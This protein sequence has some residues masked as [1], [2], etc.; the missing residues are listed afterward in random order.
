MSE[1]NHKNEKDDDKQMA[2]QDEE[3]VPDLEASDNDISNLPRNLGSMTRFMEMGISS[4]APRNSFVEKLE[5]EHIQ[6]I[7]DNAH[8][9]DLNEIKH[10]QR[11]RWF[12]L[13]YAVMGLAFL[14]FLILYLLPTDKDSFDEILKL[15]VVFAGGLGSGFGL[16]TVLDKKN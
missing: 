11:G 14:A 16:K 4:I 10:A 6:Q 1:Q 7:I 9:G 8:K 5:P 12:Q 3:S 2:M 15:L 13:I